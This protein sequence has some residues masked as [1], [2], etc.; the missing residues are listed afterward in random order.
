MK[1]LVA[2]IS[3]LI[4]IFFI[5]LF[6]YFKK[7]TYEMEYDLKD[8]HIKESY[9]SKD[10]YYLFELKYKN[11]TYAFIT[12][13]KY[14]NKRKLITEVKV[15]KS[16]D[17][18]CLESKSNLIKTYPVC[19]NE[20]EQIIEN[21]EINLNVKDIYADYNIYN[22]NH[23]N[24]LLWNYHNFVLLNDDNKK[25]IKVLKKDEYNLPLVTTYDKYLVVADKNDGYTF[26]KIYLIDKTNGKVKTIN[27]RYDLYYNDT[28]FLGRYKNNI[29]LYDKKQEQEYYLSLKKEKIYKTSNKV[30]INNKWEEVSTYKLKNELVSFQN[31]NV[32]N[33]EVINNN[34]YITFKDYKIKVSDMN[35]K[36]LVKYKD[37]D[38]YFLSDNTLY[39]YNPY[40][41]IIPLL[42]YSEWLF[43]YQNM[44]YIFD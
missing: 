18:I 12:F 8:I 15:N 22:L 3:M 28:Y 7:T 32:Y 34:L 41:G 19:R 37:L 27:L 23:K 33:Y 4:F 31:E 24:Y 1:K 25:E 21:K 2:V 42:S 20:E 38:A 14:T 17:T 13:D 39:Y 9:D 29:Y 6:F 40:E 35:I 16:D 5:F 11:E 10:N 36:L 43:N 30:L 44:I 26:N